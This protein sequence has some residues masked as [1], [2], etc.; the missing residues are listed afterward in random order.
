MPAPARRASARNSPS[1]HARGSAPNTNSPSSFQNQYVGGLHGSG[2]DGR[3]A[4]RQ[5]ALLAELGLGLG[6][7]GSSRRL[8]HRSQTRPA[9]ITL[10]MRLG[11]AAGAWAPH[12]LQALVAKLWDGVEDCGSLYSEH[13]VTT[14]KGLA[15]SQ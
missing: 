15:K 3:R 1:H 5:H 10:R 11:C 13:R 2:S 12:R 14:S 6:F 9:R 8:V 7:G 4:R